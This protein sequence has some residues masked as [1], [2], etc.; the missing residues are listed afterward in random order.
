MVTG[1][2]PM[3]DQSANQDREDRI[4]AMR[5]VASLPHNKETCLRIFELARELVDWREAISPPTFPGAAL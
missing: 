3:T 5:I 2:L 4:A 1:Y